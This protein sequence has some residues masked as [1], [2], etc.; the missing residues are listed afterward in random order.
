MIVNTGKKQEE[1]EANIQVEKGKIKRTKEYKYLG[2]WITES[3]TVE[4]RLEEITNK[5]RGMIAEMKW[6]GDESKTGIMSTS[7]Q[8]TLFEKNGKADK[9][10][11]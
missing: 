11:R 4:R 5:A 9:T 6:I 8:L 10:C 3:G 2:N 7:I 1:K